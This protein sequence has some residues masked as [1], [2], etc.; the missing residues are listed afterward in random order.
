MNLRKALGPS[1]S[2]DV[3]ASNDHVKAS[4]YIDTIDDQVKASVYHNDSVTF[5]YE[6]N[7]KAAKA[8]LVKGS[9]RIPLEIE[10]N[11]T[12]MNIV[13]SVGAWLTTVLPAIRYWNEIKSDKTC[14][15]GDAVIKIGGI[16]AGKDANGMHVV[17]QIAFY[18]DKDKVMCHLYNTTQKILVNGHGYKRLIDIFL[19]PFFEAKVENSMKDIKRVNEEVSL[20]YGVKTTKTTWIKD[21][22]DLRG[23]NL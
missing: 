21:Y 11:S 22:G 23:C 7:D 16:K 18:V 5:D 13:F 14:K 10:E 4:D 3:D 15:V 8:K 9:K 6:L 2:K 1:V 20:K 19:R 12:S 17:S